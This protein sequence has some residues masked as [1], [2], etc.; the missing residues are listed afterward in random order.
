MHMN[1]NSKFTQKKGK[2][3][4]FIVYIP[5]RIRTFGLFV[6]F[7]RTGIMQQQRKKNGGKK[8]TSHAL[9]KQSNTNYI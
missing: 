7:K 1:G 9:Y 2:E 3:K 6:I 4:Y 5:P 8:F